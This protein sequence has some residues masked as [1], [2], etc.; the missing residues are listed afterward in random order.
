MT[1]TEA[2]TTAVEH[3]V[4]VHAAAVDDAPPP[5]R[6]WDRPVSGCRWPCRHDEEYCCGIT[7]PTAII[8]FAIALAIGM[9]MFVIYS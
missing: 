4:R 2:D 1:E 8:W 7:K 9:A 6:C 5:L 3:V